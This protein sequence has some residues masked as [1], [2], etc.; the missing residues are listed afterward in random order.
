MLL[1]CPE[2]TPLQKPPATAPHADDCFAQRG[3]MAQ[4][5]MN[6]RWGEICQQLASEH[7]PDQFA[8]LSGELSL[9]LDQR[10]NQLRGL[11]DAELAVTRMQRKS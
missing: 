4:H 10:Q 7:D 2:T 5:E 1:T 6:S 9:L 11:R 8:K 3:A